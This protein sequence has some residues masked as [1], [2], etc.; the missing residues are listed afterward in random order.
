MIVER[1]IEEQKR[2]AELA[3]LYDA[4]GHVRY[5]G[6]VDCSYYGGKIIGGIVII[7]IDSLE[8]VQ[9]SHAV[10][11]P[12]FPY[13]PG[14]LAYREAKAMIKA[15][16]KVK[17]QVDILMIDGFGINHP[18][19]CGLA[20]YVG[21]K[22]DMPAIG[23]GKSFL[24]GEIREDD[25][26]YQE[27]ERVGKLVFSATSKKPIYVSPGHKISLDTS[28]ELIEKCMAGHRL[29]EPTRLA[30]EYV[31]SLKNNMR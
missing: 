7:D 10:L 14:F 20:T 4:F 23:V 15:I 3:L 16:R 28:V 6:G 29:P 2:L 25:F 9:K 1:L 19:R 13:I 17:D 12:D 8:P 22:L 18:R 24:C 26:V 27:D 5:L 31:T 11:T 21:L 30:H